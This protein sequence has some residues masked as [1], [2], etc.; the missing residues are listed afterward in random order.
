MMLNGVADRRVKL[1]VKAQGSK[2]YNVLQDV[3]W[4][5]N[6]HWYAINNQWIDKLRI[7]YLDVL[8]SMSLM[9]N[10]FSWDPV[11]CANAKQKLGLIK[12]NLKSTRA[13]L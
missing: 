6:M 7:E 1:F 3:T 5:C 12:M 2:H 4:L 11:M 10:G 9:H 8:D 13:G